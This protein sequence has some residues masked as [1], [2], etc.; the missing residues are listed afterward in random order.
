[1]YSELHAGAILKCKL[2]KD[3]GK[4][5]EGTCSSVIFDTIALMNKHLPK[6]CCQKKKKK[7]LLPQKEKK[8]L[9]KV[10]PQKAENSYCK[11]HSSPFP[12]HGIYLKMIG[13]NYS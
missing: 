12:K 2:S 9:K 13:F 8:N 1:M 11:N 3:C 4:F 10:Y 5:R 6:W 7:I